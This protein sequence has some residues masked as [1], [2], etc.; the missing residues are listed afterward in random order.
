MKKSIFI[1]SL[2]T[3]VALAFSSC[4]KEP[5]QTKPEGIMPQ[6]VEILV[7]GGHLHGSN[8]HGNPTYTNIA[9]PL[10]N[11]AQLTLELQSDGKTY[12]LKGNTPL[13]LMAHMVWSSE[14]TFLDKDN[15]RVNP[16]YTTNGVE[17][18][19]QFFLTAE[20]MR[21]YTPGETVQGASIN[22]SLEQV[23]SGFIYRDTNPEHLMYEPHEG[24]HHHHSGSVASLRHE[25]DEEEV[26]L[27]EKNIGFKGYF[28]NPDTKKAENFIGVREE[29]VAFDL[30]YHLVRFATPNKK[31]MGNQFRSAFAWEQSFSALTICSFK[32][33]V[34][35]VTKRPKD[36]AS[37]N[38][39]ISD[40]AKEFNLTPEQVKTMY[41]EASNIPNHQENDPD[42]YHM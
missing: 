22:K 30:V 23:M 8:F 6:K 10:K 36:E 28:H 37:F 4:K 25:E 5:V 7:R 39:F 40:I 16:Y 27:S 15:K 13:R 21:Q 2:A 9:F 34:R 42:E 26:E 20:N 19:C 33:P 1:L 12:A 17:D 18:V 31:K 32:V 24:H 38:N 29:H 14:I 41:N 35:I 11:K 3:T